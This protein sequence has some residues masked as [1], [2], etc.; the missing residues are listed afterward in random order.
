[1]ERWGGGRSAWETSVRGIQCDTQT[2]V[3]ASPRHVQTIR[4]AER[5]RVWINRSTGLP[6]L[7]F[8]ASGG[9][10]KTGIGAK[11]F[12]IVQKIRTVKAKPD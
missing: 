5:P 1:M 2:C 11:G 4:D 7:F 12:T 9:N 3:T 8:V 10:N 6:E